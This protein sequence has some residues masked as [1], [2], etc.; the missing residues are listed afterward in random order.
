ML[1]VADVVGSPDEGTVDR[2]LD[3]GV[4]EGSTV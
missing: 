2:G 3:L 1:T 4:V